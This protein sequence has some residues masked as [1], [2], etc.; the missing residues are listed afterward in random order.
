MSDW[1]YVQNGQTK[2][3]VT[4]DQLKALADAGVVTIATPVWKS[5]YADWIPLS[6]SDFAY[7]DIAGPAVT[8]GA[9]GAALQAGPAYAAGSY[10]V[11]DQ[12]MWRFFTRALTERY[13]KF[14]GRARRKEYWSYVL[15]L[16]ISLVVFS[17]IGVAIDIA[18]G[19]IGPDQE[20]PPT[21]VA[22]I[23]LPMLF[24][25]ATLLPSLAITVRRLHDIGL[26]GWLILVGL[27]PW[28][29]AIALIVMMC[30]PTNF[31]PNKHGPAPLAPPQ[32]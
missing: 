21:P 29:G 26:T 5:G 3:P 1:H 11:D 27:I 16:V 12:S 8:A 4:D 15:F 28:V 18:V 20:M 9:G 17:V 19:N 23:A 31:G 13:V 32:S 6:Q 30:L 10:E 14:T 25:L 2:G 24:N 7:K 22:A